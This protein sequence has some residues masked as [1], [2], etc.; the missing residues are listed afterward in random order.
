MTSSQNDLAAWLRRKWETDR[1]EIEE[2]GVTELRRLGESLNSAARSAQRSIYADMAAWTERTRA[3][4]MRTW[5]LPAAAGPAADGQLVQQARHADVAR[6]EAA[7][8]A[9]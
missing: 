9:R 3:L 5:L 7:A 8:A 4:L 2:T 6:G 1:R